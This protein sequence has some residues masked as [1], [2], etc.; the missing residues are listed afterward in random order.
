MKAFFLFL[1]RNSATAKIFNGIQVSENINGF[2]FQLPKIEKVE[3]EKFIIRLDKTNPAEVLNGKIREI[4]LKTHGAWRFKDAKSVTASKPK[5]ETKN[6]IIFTSKR[7][8]D[9][10][11]DILSGTPNGEF[12]GTQILKPGDAVG[13][14]HKGTMYQLMNDEGKPFMTHLTAKKISKQESKS[15]I[16]KFNQKYGKKS[17][18]GGYTFA[19]IL[20]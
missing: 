2:L 5:K 7:W 4:Y 6:I 15:Q 18:G 20:K 13:F 3:K 16:E 17:K 1:D 11:L 12:P 14:T 9:I 8:P 19:E 10:N